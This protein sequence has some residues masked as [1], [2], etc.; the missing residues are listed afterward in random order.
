MSYLGAHKTNSLLPQV[1][2]TGEASGPGLLE[3]EGPTS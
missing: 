3:R 2:G 1:S